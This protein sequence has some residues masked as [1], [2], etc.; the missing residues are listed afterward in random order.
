[1]LKILPIAIACSALVSC[2]TIVDSRPTEPV[3]RPQ[4]AHQVKR[5]ST[6]ID[7]DAMSPAKIQNELALAETNY[8]V[9]TKDRNGNFSIVPVATKMGRGSYLIRSSNLRSGVFTDPGTSQKLV[10]AVGVMVEA[11]LTITSGNFNLSN[12]NA[13]SAG[14]NSK[15]VSGNVRIKNIGVNSALLND[16]IGEAVKN[17]DQASLQTAANVSSN[18]NRYLNDN[19]TTLVPHIIETSAPSAPSPSAPSSAVAQN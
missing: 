19:A 18:V 12:F 1:M 10:V 4:A 3:A 13:L 2:T 5:G 17:L 14:F 6:T 11:Q 9:F 15:K 7:F 8:E 16:S